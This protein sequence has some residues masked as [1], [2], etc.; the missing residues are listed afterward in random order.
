[1]MKRTIIA[2]I[3]ILISIAGF[4]EGA[5]V[6]SFEELGDFWFVQDLHMNPGDNILIEITGVTQTIVEAGY[7]SGSWHLGLVNEHGYVVGWA[8]NAWS[9]Y[10]DHEGWLTGK[11][12]GSS[13]VD[14]WG[15]RIGLAMGQKPS[16]AYL[17]YDAL[18]DGWWFGNGQLGSQFDLDAGD[19][20]FDQS[21][22][23][24]NGVVGDMSAFGAFST[25]PVARIPAI[26]VIPE[27]L[28]FALLGLGG[29]FIRKTETERMG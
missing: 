18:D 19:L 13:L 27:P 16:G 26:T 20:F 23:A 8:F 10:P 9:P 1:M 14:E 11:Y 7:D 17:V 3:I 29:L 4:A 2:L 28:T 24:F 5:V 6:T 22:L 21:L 25:D 15:N 12:S